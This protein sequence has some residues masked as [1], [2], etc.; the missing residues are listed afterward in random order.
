MYCF[1]HEKLN[2]LPDMLHVIIK[3][4]YVLSFHCKYRLFGGGSWDIL[5]N[6]ILLCTHQT[7]SNTENSKKLDADQFS[8]TAMSE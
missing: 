4:K 6:C 5:Q 3:K 2:T 7:Y 8:K 1:V